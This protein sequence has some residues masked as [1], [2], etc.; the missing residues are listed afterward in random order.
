MGVRVICSFAGARIV[1]L[2][3]TKTHEENVLDAC[4]FE[5]EGAGVIYRITQAEVARGEKAPD[6]L[7]EVRAQVR[8]A[9]AN[10]REARRAVGQ[11]EARFRVYQAEVAARRERGQW[12]PEHFVWLDSL[13]GDDVESVKRHV[14]VLGFD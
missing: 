10:V 8:R 13:L 2:G 3:Q 5:L 6:A 1:V 9:V 7:A 4:E 11:K 12:G 14:G